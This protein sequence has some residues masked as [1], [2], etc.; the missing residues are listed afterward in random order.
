MTHFPPFF[1][2][3]RISP[4]LAPPTCGMVLGSPSDRM[5]GMARRTLECVTATMTFALPCPFAEFFGMRP[6][7]CWNPEAGDRKVPLASA[8]TS[9]MLSKGVPSQSS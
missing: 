5:H 9:S 6:P 3:S 4:T 1:W 2:T 8:S 7:F